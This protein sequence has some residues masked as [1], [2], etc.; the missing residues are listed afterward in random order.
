[1]VETAKRREIVVSKED[2]AFLMKL[3][4]VTNQTLYTALNLEN[5]EVGKRGRIRK[6]ALERGGEVMVW[7]KEIE[8]I[9]DADGM[10]VQTF[11]NGARLEISKLTG[12]AR[13]I[14]KEEEVASF[15]NISVAMLYDIQSVAYHLG[16]KGEYLNRQPA[17]ST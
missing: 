4:G 15:D 3:F 8:T 1:M 14:Y 16:K 2:R 12:D 13:I 10:M 11:P 7:L 17:R 5:P 6:A 9:H